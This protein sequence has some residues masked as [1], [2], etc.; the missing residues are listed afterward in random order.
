MQWYTCWPKIGKYVPA[1]KTHDELDI[2]QYFGKVGG[3]YLARSWQKS[4]T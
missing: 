1:E 2:R 4:S 3:A